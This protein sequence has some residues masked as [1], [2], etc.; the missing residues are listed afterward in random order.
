MN[1][2]SAYRSADRI[3]ILHILPYLPTPPQ[4][5]GAMRIYHILKHLSSEYEVYVIAYGDQGDEEEFYREFPELKERSLILKR[6]DYGRR[7]RFHQFRAFLSD[8]SFWY[9]KTFSQQMQDAID[10]IG[11]TIHLDLILFEFPMLGQFRFPDSVMRVMDSHNV[12]YHL[13]HRM[14]SVKQDPLRRF[15][16]QRE[17]G[18]V[19]AEEG[20]IAS[21]QDAL[22]VT[23][24]T[25]ATLFDELVPDVPKIVIPNGVDVEYYKPTVPEVMN[26]KES[27]TTL[28]FSG[29]M[30]YVPNYDGMLYFIDEIYPLIL[31]KR[32][33]VRLRIVGKNPPE[34]LKKRR[35]HQIEITGYVEDVRPYILESDLYVVPLRMGGG[36]RL[37][38][39]QAMAMKVPIISTTIGAEG[40]DA[41]DGTH[42]LLRD[43][44]KEFAEAT[45]ELM[46]NSSLKK[47]LAENAYQ[48]VREEY[49]WRTIG[50]R[51]DAAFHYLMKQKN[52]K[53]ASTLLMQN[54]E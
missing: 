31:E 46:N 7:N 32:P 53:A 37:K 29:M 19:K 36:T 1:S 39:L 25:D 24:S 43:D 14:S 10:R 35:N 42:A 17:S 12:E 21:D 18:K 26:S 15:F 48:F 45:L 16:Y 2:L 27:T 3:K 51:I 4:F 50:R 54:I 47:K 38:I 41:V 11:S 20:E 9:T 44:P 6:S 8:H 49:D 52:G 33:S 34:L 28:V 40:L 22:F 5:G 13:L 30:G 23:S